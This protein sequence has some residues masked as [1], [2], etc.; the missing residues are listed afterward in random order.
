VLYGSPTWAAK[1]HDAPIFDLGYADG[2]H[3]GINYIGALN[4]SYGSISGPSKVR[5][6]FIVTGGDRTVR[7]AGVRIKRISG[8]GDLT[9]RLETGAGAEIESVAVPAS[10]ITTGLY[11]TVD[12]RAHL[13]GSTWAVVNFAAPHVLANGATYNLVLSAPAGTEYIAVPVQDGTTKGMVSRCFTDGDGQKT[14]DGGS[15]WTY[16]Y[17]YLDNGR[18]DLQFY[19]R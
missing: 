12:D 14:T 6:H 5:E 17:P 4:D 8:T 2:T 13:S 16:L 7:T 18:Q 15:V 10:A 3:D 11:P 1:D 19:F 9:I